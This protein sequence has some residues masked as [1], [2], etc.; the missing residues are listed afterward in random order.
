MKADRL[1]PVPDADFQAAAAH[2]VEH[3]GVLGHPDRQLQRQGDDAGAEA[4][5]RGLRGDLRQE[6]ERRRQA[7][8]VFVEM[9]LGDPGGIEA[10]ALG[11]HDLLGGQPIALGGGAWSSRRVKKPRRFSCL[12]EAFRR[13]PVGREWPR[14]R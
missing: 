10:A 7:A 6:D 9:V 3:R 4:D 12:P 8:F 13:T 5:A 11:M 1:P 2:Q 14:P